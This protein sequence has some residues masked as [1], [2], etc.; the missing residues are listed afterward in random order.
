MH[1]GLIAAHGWDYWRRY[2]RAWRNDPVVRQLLDLDGVGTDETSRATFVAAAASAAAGV[3]LLGSFRGAW[4]F[5]ID[6]PLFN[7]LLAAFENAM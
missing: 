6:E 2:V 1:A 3:N 4:R 5:P 7:Q